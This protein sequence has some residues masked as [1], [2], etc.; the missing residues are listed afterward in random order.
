MHFHCAAC[1]RSP[2]RRGASSKHTAMHLPLSGRSSMEHTAMH[3][4][5]AERSSSSTSARR[6][7]VPRHVAMQ[8]LPAERPPERSRGRDGA[9]LRHV[10]D[11]SVGA[12]LFR[13][14]PQCISPLLHGRRSDLLVGTGLLGAYSNAPSPI[15]LL[16]AMA[17][18]AGLTLKGATDMFNCSQDPGRSCGPSAVK[19]R[20]YEPSFRHRM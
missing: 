12:E 20:S 16:H 19:H 6:R 10:N 14:I 7:A 15:L 2:R 13:S 5:P 8:L 11:H 9:P 1:R 18:R 4:H 3:I 17:V